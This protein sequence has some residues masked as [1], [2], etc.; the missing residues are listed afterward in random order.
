MQGMSEENTNRMQKY[1]PGIILG[2]ILLADIRWGPFAAILWWSY[3]LA[4][5]HVDQMTA[6][7]A[8]LAKN[9]FLAFVIAAPLILP[10][11]EYSQISTRAQLTVDDNLVYSLPPLRLLGLIIP[12]LVSNHEWVLY[13][14]GTT[15]LLA[16]VV[17]IA[18]KIDGPRK[19][20]L[21]AICASLVFSL[22][23]YLPG[24]GLL[25]GLPGIDLLRVPS[26]ALF[27]TGLGLSALAGTGMDRV[28]EGIGQPHRRR[29]NLILTGLMTLSI[30]LGSGL[31]ILGEKL[32]RGL[33]WGILFLLIGA[34]WILF[35]I[36]DKIP[37]RYWIPG[38]IIL[39]IFELAIIDSSA[40][41][42]RPATG[43]LSEGE[44]VAQFL[45]AKTGSF[46]TYSPSYSL[47]QH[48]AAVYQIEL[49]DGVDPMQ[50]TSYA[51]FME[52][53]SGVPRAGYHVTIPTY[54]SGN[55]DIDN[56]GYT[57]DPRLLGLLNVRY[58]IS[59]FDIASPSLI[60]ETQIDE[61]R[62]YRNLFEA[63]RAW[64]QP[65]PSR[66]NTSETPVEQIYWSPNR[67][68]LVATGPG[69]LFLSEIAYPGW[70]ARVGGKTWQI[71]VVNEVFRSINLPEGEHK[72]EFSFLP[73]SL[74]IG[75]SFW[76][77]ALVVYIG[78][79]IRKHG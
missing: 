73:L 37:V 9:S 24:M 19:F 33:G 70:R 71:E 27:L 67:I 11:L 72:V 39:T 23:V 44:D 10:L 40:I 47:P 15:I 57:P 5:S 6:R 17:L 65:P 38:I 2:I 50:L 25:F 45:S 63:P 52:R 7:L 30:G 16:T 1:W 4:H 78:G 28:L 20:W 53:A 42:W 55:P 62:I 75:F 46:R 31:L 34:I 18:G 36:G 56:Q 12:D 69:R 64:I 68:E 66:S 77:V 49:T 35:K 48:T 29:I 8:N 79:K 21:L 3:G 74:Y 32:P 59:A 58:V 14:G 22:G 61:T 13:S 41:S 26:R 43:V 51:E 54:A 60:Y 76:A